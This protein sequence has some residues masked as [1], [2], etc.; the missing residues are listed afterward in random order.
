MIDSK[1]LT[2]AILICLILPHE[3]LN[4]CRDKFYHILFTAPGGKINRTQV[5]KN[6]PAD[7]RNLGLNQPKK[8]KPA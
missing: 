8:V 1:K 2:G 3:Y 4:Y 7:S 6:I 5:I